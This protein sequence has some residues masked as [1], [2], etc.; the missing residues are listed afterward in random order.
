[1]TYPPTGISAPGAWTGM[2]WMATLEAP[3]DPSRQVGQGL[4]G[5]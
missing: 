2:Q 5:R 1:M 4:G 3:A